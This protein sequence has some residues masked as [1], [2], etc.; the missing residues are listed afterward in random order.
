LQTAQTVEQD[1]D[2]TEICVFAQRNAL[3]RLFL[4]RRFD[5]ADLV[6]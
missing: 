1:R 3:E 2:A 6:A 5:E 4:W